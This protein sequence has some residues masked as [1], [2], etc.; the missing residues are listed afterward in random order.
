ML[1]KV[2]NNMKSS[3]MYAHASVHVFVPS[4][5]KIKSAPHTQS[6]S[7]LASSVI[8]LSRVYSRTQK[9]ASKTRCITPAL[10]RSVNCA[11]CE[12]VQ[13]GT[14]WRND[15]PC[16]LVCFFFFAPHWWN[17]SRTPTHL[18]GARSQSFA[19]FISGARC[20]SSAAGHWLFQVV[21]SCE[22]VAPKLDRR[23]QGPPANW[24]TSHKYIDALWNRIKA[25]N[26]SDKKKQ[27][28]NPSQRGADSKQLTVPSWSRIVPSSF[29][30]RIQNVRLASPVTEVLATRIETQT[31]GWSFKIAK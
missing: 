20:P 12:S 29:H 5:R 25:N 22:T 11:R 31:S 17:V 26:Q 27:T 1:D 21:W 7:S 24:I 30:L 8:Q 10:R 15:L 3:R 23:R 16:A 9:C 13:G 19:E 2:Q 28:Y 14:C 18:A 4:L 6:R